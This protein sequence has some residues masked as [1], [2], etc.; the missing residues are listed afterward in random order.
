MSIAPLRTTSRALRAASRALA[1]RTAFS[2]ILRAVAGF[3][4]KN[5][6]ELVADD[7]LDDA[8]HLARDELGLGLRVERRIGVLHA[9]DR[10]E[11]FANVFAGEALLHLFEEVLRGAV[12][13]EHARERG[14]EPGEVR[15]AVLV[16]DVVR[17]RE[18]L[19]GVASSSTAARPR[20][21]SA[22]RSRPAPRR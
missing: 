11:P 4:S 3:S 6:A 20:R 5:C 14:A 17:V 22:R 10:G 9:D 15:A 7:G 12:G 13:V 18:D 21:R 1:A 19:L 16:V 2:M 8:L